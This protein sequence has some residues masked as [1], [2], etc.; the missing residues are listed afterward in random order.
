MATMASNTELE[1][2]STE[3]SYSNDGIT[4]SHHHTPAISQIAT[5][6]LTI[7]RIRPL[8][9]ATPQANQEPA[10]PSRARSVGL[11]CTMACISFLNTFTSGTLT[12]ALPTIARDLS[13]PTN[14]LLW[15]AAVYALALSTTLLLLGAV[16]DVVGNRRIF[17]TG[18]VLFSIWMLA[19]AFSQSAYQ[20]IVFRTLQGVSMSFCLPTAVSTITATFPSG[21]P[22][23]IAFA[24]FGGGSPVG[25]AVGLV[26][27]GVIVQASS[28]RTAY[29]LAAGL[30]AGISVL[31]WFTMPKESPVP[32]WQRRLL[33]DFDWVGVG[34]AVGSLALLSYIF[35]E[36]AYSG[37][38]LKKAYNSVL[39]AVGVLLIP[40]FVFWVGRRERLGRH[41][42]L[43]NSIWRSREFTVICVTVFL[44]W[45]WF[46]AFGYW[47]TLYFQ[48]TQG[49]DALQTALRFLPLVVV[50][51]GTNVLA[52]LI[53]DKVSASTLV[54][55]GGILS[56]IGPLLFAVQDPSWIYWAGGFPA[57]ALAVVSSDLLFN[58]SNLVI[59]SSF[60][61]SDQALAGSVFN[62]VSQLGNSIGLAVT[63]IIAS[64][65]TNAVERQA[66]IAD[67]YAMLKGYRS[68]FWTCFAAAVAST[69]ISSIGL[70]EIGKVGAKK[71]V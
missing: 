57:M 50:G 56:A 9:T 60:P 46:N 21:R 2:Q 6:I 59:T 61:S 19:V 69:I 65:V 27:G 1:F 49:L 22:R 34:T 67:P 71:D 8:V 3:T 44:V 31:A 4:P 64:A 17:I 38:V 10:T 53:M 20:L 43:P 25:F 52:G 48:N 15:P 45:S 58:I 41:A 33:H 36:L 28:W 63:A 39:L 66:G 30:G 55:V 16:A 13:L 40:F 5:S 26:L 14:L 70:R 54:L 12:V 62:T 11:M 68:A 32:N 7:D 47:S 23:N 18:T 37:S 24:V 51:V 29:Y 42:I 35:A